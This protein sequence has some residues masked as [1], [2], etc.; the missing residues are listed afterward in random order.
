MELFG[1]TG[2]KKE[3]KRNYIP[4]ADRIRPER[5]EDFVGQEHILGPG[6]F[7]RS[8]IEKDQLQSLIFWGP[9]GTGKTTLARIIGK[10]V[11]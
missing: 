5:L 11:V 9:P 6:R 1:A 3:E 8:L 4:L 10:S 2:R 7:L